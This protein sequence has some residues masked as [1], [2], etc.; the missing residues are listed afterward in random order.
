MENA[1]KALIIAGAILLS[2][3]IIALGVFVFNQARGAMGNT[4]LDDQKA[5]ANNQKFEA[6]EGSKVKGSQ[7]KALLDIVRT[8]NN[9][10]SNDNDYQK[11]T[12][13]GKSE[14]SDLSSMKNSIQSSSE[15]KVSITGYSTSGSTKGYVSAITIDSTGVSSGDAKKP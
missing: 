11:V 1:S 8:N 6:Y 3:L 10:F 7:V 9:S 13:N 2:I 14:A 12:V 4:G 5:S 15:Y